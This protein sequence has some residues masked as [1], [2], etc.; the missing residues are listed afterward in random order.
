MNIKKF[1]SV[2]SERRNYSL[3]VLV[4][5]LALSP[6]LAHVI[7]P[8]YEANAEVAFVGNPDGAI[9]PILDLPDLVTSPGV[10]ERAA[11]EM[12]DPSAFPLDSLYLTT[13]SKVV[14]RSSELSI[15][16][17]S[18]DPERAIL[19]VNA[20]AKATVYEYKELARRPV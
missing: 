16:V 11:K 7:R 3:A 5:A 19:Q 6:L 1:G 15:V 10:I 13:S 20:V 14:P 8:T 4:I 17:R 2:I 18:K 9:L 12:N